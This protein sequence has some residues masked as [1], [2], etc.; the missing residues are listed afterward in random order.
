M[1]KLKNHT[2]SFQFSQEKVIDLYELVGFSENSPKSK[3]ECF[4]DFF[5]KLLLNNLSPAPQSPN[6]EQKPESK[7]SS[8]Y[9]KWTPAQQRAI[10][11]AYEKTK[12]KERAKAEVKIELL[13]TQNR[14]KEENRKRKDFYRNQNR[15]SSIDMGD[16]EGVPDDYI[17]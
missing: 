16:S 2:I 11:F 9:Q 1:D 8:E 3:S 14:L 17:F 10:E 15:K 6:G 4:R 5:E 7:P 13:E 12:A